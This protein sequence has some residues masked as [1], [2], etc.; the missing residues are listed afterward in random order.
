MKAKCCLKTEYRVHCRDDDSRCADHCRKFEVWQLQE[1]KT[2]LQSVEG[3]INALCSSMYSKEQHDDLLYDFGKSVNFINEWKCHILQFE[4]QEIA[5]QSFIQK[6]TEYSVFIVMDWTMKFLQSDFVKSS[7]IGMLRGEWTITLAVLSRVMERG[8]FFVS[9]YNH[10]FNSC[11]QDW[12]SVLS[13]LESLLITVRSSIP[14]VK[15]AY[16]KS[17]EAGCYYN[18]QLI[19]AA[20][21]VG[22]RV[23]VSLPRYDF[24]EP[25]SEKT[26][27]T[28]SYFL[29]KVP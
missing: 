24:S 23:G 3:K 29:W 19:V 14:K 17:D 1:T 26:Y 10:L 27:A 11:S 7:A 9:F 18:S 20:R 12:F 25:Q 8:I 22:E 15:K 16:L 13:I 6:L 2:V 5:K 4:S 28:E 21:D